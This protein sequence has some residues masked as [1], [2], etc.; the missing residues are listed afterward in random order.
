M[1]NITWVDGIPYVEDPM[2]GEMRIAI[3]NELMDGEYYD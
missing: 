1:E 2:D 3:S